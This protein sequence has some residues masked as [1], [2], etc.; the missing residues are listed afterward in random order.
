MGPARSFSM[1][2]VKNMKMG[3]WNLF[4]ELYLLTFVT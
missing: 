2:L 3:I 1:T 4:T